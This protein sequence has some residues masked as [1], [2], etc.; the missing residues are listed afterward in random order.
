MQGDR[1]MNLLHRVKA[2]LKRRKE[3]RLGIPANS[4]LGNVHVRHRNLEFGENSYMNSG[5]VLNGAKA[6]VKIGDYC[7]IGYNVSIISE[8]HNPDNIQAK[9]T[10]PVKIGSHVWIGNNA[11]IVPDVQI[12]DNTVIGANS[13]VTRS[14]PSNVVAAGAPCE[15]KR[16]K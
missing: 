16:R 7:C 1:K 12:G 13:V 5:H 10:A 8:T 15:V 4:R 14:I 6:P 11:V 3:H 2:T 9:H